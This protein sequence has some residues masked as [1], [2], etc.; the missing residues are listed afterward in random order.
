MT[1][2]KN[3]ETEISTPVPSPFWEPGQ[4]YRPPHLT[5]LEQVLARIRLHKIPLIPSVQSFL[6][7]DEDEDENFYDQ[8]YDIDMRC[9][10]RLYLKKRKNR[11]REAN[12]LESSGNEANF[13]KTESE[14]RLE[15]EG[16]LEYL[17]VETLENELQYVPNEVGTIEIE[18][19][20]I[21]C[22]DLELVETR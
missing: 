15:L 6:I 4:H 14:V 5:S 2:S 10:R 7:H 21:E 11:I 9:E 12:K 19:Q 16:E 13:F 20:S 1:W 3:Q 8:Y 22:E 18:L 17:F